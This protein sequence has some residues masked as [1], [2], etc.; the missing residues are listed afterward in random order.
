MTEL[1]LDDNDDD[2][3]LWLTKVE[4]LH[5]LALRLPCCI[6]AAGLALFCICTAICAGSAF[7]GVQL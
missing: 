7:D 1:K 4:F 5:Y 3:D 6:L 2:D